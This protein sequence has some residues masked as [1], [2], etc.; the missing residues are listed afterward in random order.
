MPAGKMEGG[1]VD[2][3]ARLRRIPNHPRPGVTFIDVLPL[4]GA[5]DSFTAAIRALADVS[6]DLAA[7]VIVAPEARGFLVGAPLA[8]ARGIGFVPV[9]KKGKLPWKVERVTYALEYGTDTVEIH[10][11]AIPPGARVLV[12]DDLLATGGT[13]R[14]AIE[15]VERLG[16]TVTGTAF[17]V[18]L[19]D[20]GAR[21]GALRGRVVR[22]V[23]RIREHDDSG[24]AEPHGA[25]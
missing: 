18:E 12:V 24:T 8:L 16:G 15:L 4:L 17:L 11:D 6:S 21:T 10:R 23:L 2:L 22:S 3:A 14:A 7:D 25:A 20:L 19:E 9:R 13:V 1:D 5:G